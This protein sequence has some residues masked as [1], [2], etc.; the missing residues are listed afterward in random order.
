MEFFNQ[1][2][3]RS[4]PDKFMF[5]A[6]LI[7]ALALIVTLISGKSQDTLTVY[8]GDADVSIATDE[9]TL[10][11]DVNMQ[12]Y[13]D[14]ELGFSLNIPSSWQEVKEKGVSTFIHKESGS[15]LA[16]ETYDYDPY[17][18]N[19][20]SEGMSSLVA[21]A[22][23]TFT[24][25]NKSSDTSYELLYQDKG[26]T[27]YDYIEMVYWDRSNV[28]KLIAVFNDENYGKIKSY[29]E[30][31]FNSFVWD[32]QN[33]IPDGYGLAFID[34]YGFEMG[35][36]DGWTTGTS[37]NTYVAMDESTGSQMTVQVETGNTSSLESL[38]ASDMAEI[39][40]GG[41]SNFMFSDFKTSATMAKGQSTYIQNNV[42]WNCTS[43]LFADG[44]NLYLL[45]IDYEDGMLDD[46]VSDTLASLF[47]SFNEVSSSLES[48]GISSEAESVDGESTDSAVQYKYDTTLS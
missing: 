38:R 20:T 48:D 42:Q 24:S 21:D 39:V 15:S 36:P 41:R 46:T 1:R 14:S 44:V 17:V 5:I 12:L 31:I 6:A 19:Y 16:I 45:Q 23:Y 29:Y 47:R 32:K 27:I 28:V 26:E 9:S 3:H 37:G 43:Y 4:N 2:R 11:L 7:A 33:P 40:Q 8:N 13:S 30:A 10:K 35:V 34:A 22:G 25:F 18:N